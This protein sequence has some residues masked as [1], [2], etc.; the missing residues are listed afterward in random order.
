MGLLCA[1]CPARGGTS[2][3]A[4]AIAVHDEMVARRPELAEL[5]YQDLERSNLGEETGGA[6]RTYAIPV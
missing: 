4:S 1:G 3:I 6:D 2:K 5:L